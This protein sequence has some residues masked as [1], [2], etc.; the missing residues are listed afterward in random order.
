MKL[1]NA[2][3]GKRIREI[4][5]QRRIS[6]TQLSNLI[7]KNTS[8]ISY[9]ENGLKCM[10]LDTFIQIINALQTSADSILIDHLENN[11][12][13]ASKEL[14]IL[15]SDCSDYEALIILDAVRSLKKIL[16]EHQS[17]FGK[18]VD[19]HFTRRR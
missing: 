3:I 2:I 9:I 5:K 6:Q 1:N 15:L 4:R 8:Y 14:T 17:V 10:S 12:L 18:K 11:R 16:R 7:D 13:L 19:I